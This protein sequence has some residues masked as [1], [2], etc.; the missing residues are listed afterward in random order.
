M[1][2][3][4][5]IQSISD[6][7]TNSSSEVFLIESNEAS[8]EFF[9]EYRWY[10]STF[11]T[12]EDVKKYVMDTDN[13]LEALEHLSCV[14]WLDFDWEYLIPTLKQHKTDDEIWEFFKFKFENLVG[15][16]I[17]VMDNN[18]ID[19]LLTDIRVFNMKDENKKV[20][21]IEYEGY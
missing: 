5:C 6:I 19:D 9:K 1:K 8:D 16:S 18:Y 17:V 21:V 12:I 4:L 11:N 2:K 14:E 20:K 3:C 13:D 10:H 15:K 7:V